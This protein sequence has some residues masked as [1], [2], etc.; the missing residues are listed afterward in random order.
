MKAS[1]L[2]VKVLRTFED[3]SVQDLTNE[4]SV[5]FYNNGLLSVQNKELFEAVQEQLAYL[6]FKAEGLSLYR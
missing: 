5:L 2:E 6:I 4:A 3:G 1:K